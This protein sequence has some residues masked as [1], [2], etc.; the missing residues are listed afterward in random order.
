MDFSN[1]SLKMFLDLK[2]T[3]INHS[4]LLN[5]KHIQ[6]ILYMKPSKRSLFSTLLL[7]HEL[8]KKQQQSNLFISVINRFRVKM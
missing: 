7:T 8:F 6:Q 4:Y 3:A 2:E 5:T 1:R